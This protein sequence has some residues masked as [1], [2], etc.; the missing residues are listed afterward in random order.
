MTNDNDLGNDEELVYTPFDL[1]T[2]KKNIPSY[3]SEKL[4]EM[5]V[6]DRYFSCYKEPALVCMEELAQRRLN[7]DNF[8]FET[9][10]E[11]SLASLPKLDF[12]LPDIG[13]LMRQFVSKR[14]F[15]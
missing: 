7:G 15:R 10:I 3:S 5:I 8:D 13:D 4:C 14:T 6:C 12:S 11:K 1:D 2:V 9:Y